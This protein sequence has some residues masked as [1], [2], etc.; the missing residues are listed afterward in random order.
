MLIVRLHIDKYTVIHVLKFVRTVL[1]KTIDIFLLLSGTLKAACQLVQ[2]AGGE[3]L[4]CVVIFDLV[5]LNGKSKVPAPVKVL[6][7]L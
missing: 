2:K 3:V 6:I 4:Q 1:M 5:E 7:G